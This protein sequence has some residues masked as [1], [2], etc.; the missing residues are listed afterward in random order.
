M[1]KLAQGR[2][3]LIGQVEGFRALGVEVKRPIN[4]ALA[5]RARREDDPQ[6]QSSLDEVDDGEQ[7]E[8]PAQEDELRDN[9]PLAATQDSVGSQ[10]HF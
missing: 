9:D 8:S 5:A 6:L 1:N 7:P 10:K 4:P 2:G 3:N